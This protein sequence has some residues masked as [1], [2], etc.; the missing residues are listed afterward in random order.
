MTEKFIDN[1]SGVG[2]G[3]FGGMSSKIHSGRE[4]WFI[5]E[6]ATYMKGKTVQFEAEDK[7]K[8][9]VARNAKVVDGTTATTSNGNN[10]GKITWDD[11]RK[12]AEAAHGL[13][14]QLEPDVEDV[15]QGG[16]DNFIK[17]DRSPARVGFVNN[18]M[19][20]YAEGR[21]I[22]PKEEEEDAPF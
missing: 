2:P 12:L 11:Y 20:A 17:V 7:G 21:F 22:V 10:N 18:V 9:K 1:V 6:D 5:N 16:G 8:Y 15:A 3:K 13:A 14:K 19:R 4:Y